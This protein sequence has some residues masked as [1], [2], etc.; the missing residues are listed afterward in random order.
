MTFCL[1]AVRF[2]VEL[3]AHVLLEARRFCVLCHKTSRERYF[4]RKLKCKNCQSDNPKDSS[5][6]NTCGA[7]LRRY[8]EVGNVVLVLEPLIQGTL[9]SICEGASKSSR[10]KA[11]RPRKSDTNRLAKQIASILYSN[12]YTVPKLLVLAAAVGSAINI[13]G[14]IVEELALPQRG[15]ARK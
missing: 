15:P 9:E 3:G 6:C 5:Y 14:P 13:L 1:A 8:D 12:G 2:D 4:A 7:D 10:R 11:R